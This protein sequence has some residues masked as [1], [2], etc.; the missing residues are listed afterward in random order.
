MSLHIYYNNKQNLLRVRSKLN[1]VYVIFNE[2]NN[3]KINQNVH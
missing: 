2:N 3:I 1:N